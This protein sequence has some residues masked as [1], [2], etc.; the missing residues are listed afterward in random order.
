MANAF[1][2]DLLTVGSG[3]NALE[4]LVQADLGARGIRVHIRQ[5]ELG[6]F[7]TQAR[8]ANKEFDV[9]VA[10]VP[11][12][13]ALALSQRDVRDATVGRGAGLRRFPLA[14]PRFSCLPQREARALKRNE[15]RRG[16][17]SAT[18][19]RADARRL[20]LPLARF[21]G[22]LRAATQRRDGS[23]RRD[24]DAA[25]GRSGRNAP[26]PMS[27]FC[28]T[29]AI[30]ERRGDCRGAFAI[31][32]VFAWRAICEPL[33]TRE[34]YFPA[35]KALLSR[36]GG[37]C[38]RDGTLL[39]FDPFKP[40]EHRCPVVR[41][42]L[43]RRAARSVLDLLVPALARRARRPCGGAAS[44]WALAIGLRSLAT[45]ILD[46]YVDRYSTYPN[47]DNVLGP[48]RLFFSTYLESIWLLQICIATDLLDA[49]HRVARRRECATRSS[50]RVA[51][52]SPST[53][54]AVRIGRSGTTSRFCAARSPRRR[55]AQRRERGVRPVGHRRAPRRRAA[56]RRNAGTKARTITSSRIVDC[57]TA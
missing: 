56:R 43:S 15:P 33:L 10:G 29:T 17:R 12:D 45:S 18:A 51:R 49:T 22:H 41:R 44:A 11:G 50:S 55:R 23:A 6:T 54:R 3:D 26:S 8:A 40:H 13:V 1:E 5:V 37:R 24:G 47:V 39:E 31:A 20:D 21:A 52:S 9:L 34:L 35:D 30:G 27:L 28:W 4:Q 16:R 32:R 36:E 38:A 19:R 25:D 7:L 57:G 42:G 46:G 2:F 48:T 14:A 53:T